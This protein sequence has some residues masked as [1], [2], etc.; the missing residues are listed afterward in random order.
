MTFTNYGKLATSW[1]IG[2]NL[3]NNFIQYVAIGSGSGTVAVTDVT[4]V[5]ERDRNAITGS[6]DFD[7]AKKVQFQADFAAT[8]MSGLIL[9]EFGLFISGPTDVGSVW[10]RESFGSILFT[11]TE[12][13]QILATLEVI[14]R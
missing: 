7:T 3:T 12:E 9:T 10:Q 2:S 4:L 1:A 5:A 14:P 6:P 13:L 8:T 11:G